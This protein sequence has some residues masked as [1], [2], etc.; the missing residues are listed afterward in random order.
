MPKIDI[1][2]ESRL[3]EALKIPA[4]IDLS[5]PP[6]QKL[7]INL[8]TGGTLNAFTDMSKAVPTDCALTFSLLLQ[9][10]PLL[11]SMD[12]LLKILA[13]L[14]PLVDIVKGLPFP[15]FKAVKKFIEA[16][17]K[18]A[19]CLAIPTGAPLVPF[20]K[21]ILCLLLKVLRCLTTQ[22]KTIIAIMSGLTLQIQTAEAAGNTEQL[23]ALKCSKENADRSAQSALQAIEPIGA[24]LSLVA[25]V[26]QLAGQKPISMPAIG[27]D[28]DVDAL[29][30]VVTTLN[31]V[32]D[33]IQVITDAMGG[34]DS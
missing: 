30:T 15:P 14:G 29:Q 9:L 23:A 20:V 13:L 27:S 12:C 34:C 5:L 8:P 18:L 16:A 32:A 19:P 10:G 25:P 33:A 7:K 26:M 6:P 17:V 24:L 11:A 1:K 4:C 3:E 28:T 22:L 2:V 31:G 21:D